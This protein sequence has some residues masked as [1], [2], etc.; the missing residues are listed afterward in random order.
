[1]TTEQLTGVRHRKHNCVYLECAALPQ[2]QQREEGIVFRAEVP[3]SCREATPV[4]SMKTQNDGGARVRE[5]QVHLGKK[6][7]HTQ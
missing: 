6:G 2:A 5:V 4:H 7:E 1:M 3:R